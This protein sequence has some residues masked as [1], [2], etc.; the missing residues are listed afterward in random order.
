MAGRARRGGLREEGHGGQAGGPKPSARAAMSAAG[1]GRDFWLWTSASRHAG[2]S[3][4]SSRPYLPTIL[5]DGGLGLAAGATVLAAI[6]IFNIAGTYM[7][8]LA[9]CCW[10]KARRS[11]RAAARDAND[12]GEIRPARDRRIA[13]HREQAP[14]AL[15]LVESVLEEEPAAGHQMAARAGDDRTDR[16]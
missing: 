10:P 5:S 2:S 6:G 14:T 8:G 9:G 13:V 11:R 3:S 12:A 15:G 7:G 4:R 1:S 16:G